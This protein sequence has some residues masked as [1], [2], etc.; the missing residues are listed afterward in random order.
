[1]L[2]TNFFDSCFL[3][4]NLSKIL[5]LGLLLFLVFTL[6]SSAQEREKLLRTL[7]VSGRGVERIPT[8]LSQVNL[9]V[10]IQGK[11]AQEVQQEAARRSTAVVALL[12]SR[13]VEKLETTGISLNP[14]YS[15]ANNTQKITGYSATNTVSFRLPTERT[16]TLLDEAVKAGATKINGVSFVA[17]DEAIASAQTQ[18]LQKATQDA[19]RQA[20]AVFGSLNLQPKEI[21]SIQVNG[22]SPPP[23]AP[24]YDQVTAT[25]VSRKAATP[26]IGGEQEVQAS[27]TLQISY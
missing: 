4:G 20:N 22:A 24:V 18:A 15:Y 27:V 14:V 23:P 5:S 10:E 1:M 11:T 12:K 13:N 19:Q 26:I 2:K 8:T 6:P 17:S 21:V 7:T 25:F 9:G 3:A 16:G